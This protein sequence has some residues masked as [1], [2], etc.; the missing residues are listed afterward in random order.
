MQ[1]GRLRVLEGGLLA[2]WCVGCKEAHAI[3]VNRPWRFNGN[4]DRPTFTPS[5][6][7]TSGCKCVGWS[8]ECWC[9]YNAKHPQ[10]PAPF[11]CGRCH[12]FVTDGRIQFLSD[13]T[14]DFAGKTVDLEA[15]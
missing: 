15:F 7:I 9:T 13:C 5:I 8:G 6:L 14:H 1:K 10:D 2:F 4:Y 12:T 3:P 11:K